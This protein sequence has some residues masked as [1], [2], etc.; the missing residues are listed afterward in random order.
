MDKK[1]QL[2]DLWRISF[3]DSEAFIN[4]FFDRVYKEDNV[5]TIERD[6]KIVS[7]L[8]ML[9]YTM[10]F[11]GKEISVSYIYGACTLPSERGQGLMQQLIKEAF[12]VM[13]NRD[14]AVTVIV[15]ADPWLFDYYRDLGFT[16]AFDYTEEIYTRPNIPVYEPTV[17]VIPPEIPPV[18]S[19]YK[20]FDRKLRER[21]CCV[22]H[23]Y[24]DFITILRDIQL[25]GGQV[26]T[27]LDINEN[28]V[29]IMFLYPPEKELPLEEQHVYIKEFLYEDE[30]IR[31]LLLQE[32][33]LQ[34]NVKTA[35]YRLPF[36]GP[37]TFP[38]GMARVLDTKRIIHL[39]LRTHKNT[40]LD[41]EELGNTDIQPLTRL[42]LG[43]SS[44]EAYM[45][46]M[47]D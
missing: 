12:I 42:V 10:T 36:T 14:V 32:A 41:A 15:P 3:D 25:S 40:V 1:Q 23:T 4:L 8:H 6:G 44:R 34:N 5:L 13:K 38:M 26:L 20:F 9:P 16:E 39:W 43:Y 27:A 45:S 28:P 37:G 29:G 22:L 24:D 17:T 33:T 30:S 18:D 19:L 11:Y 21:S 2:I 31:N 46:L 47:L 7:A 35:V